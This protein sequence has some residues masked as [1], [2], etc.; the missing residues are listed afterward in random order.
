M[1]NVPVVARA[2][3]SYCVTGRTNLHCFKL[4]VCVW[5]AAGFKLNLFQKK[6]SVPSNFLNN[7]IVYI[8]LYM[9]VLGVW[10]QEA[11]RRFMS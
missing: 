2:N 1:V 9:Y 3:P 10:A 6:I 8:Y 5:H 7:A 4:Y 11:R